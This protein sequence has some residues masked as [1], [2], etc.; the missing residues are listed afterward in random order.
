MRSQ[1]DTAPSFSSRGE[2]VSRLGDVEF[3]RPYLSEALERHGLGAACL[4]YT[5]DAADE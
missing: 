5:S 2:F 3:W 1:P 4:L